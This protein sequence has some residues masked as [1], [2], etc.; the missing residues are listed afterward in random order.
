MSPINLHSV[1]FIHEAV[2]DG[3]ERTGTGEEVAAHASSD[4]APDTFDVFAEDFRTVFLPGAKR[5][6]PAVF[7]ETEGVEAVDGG[8]VLHGWEMLHGGLN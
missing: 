4:V 1:H 8:E 6:F 2:A 5:M 7:K 3:T